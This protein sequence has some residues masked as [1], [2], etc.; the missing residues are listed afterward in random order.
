MTRTLTAREHELVDKI[1]DDLEYVT[2]SDE[3]EVIRRSIH[4][5]LSEILTSDEFPE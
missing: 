4:E 5:Y 3:P 1:A 2:S